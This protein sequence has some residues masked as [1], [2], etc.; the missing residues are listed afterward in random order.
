MHH[1]SGSLTRQA[2]LSKCYSESKVLSLNIERNHGITQYWGKLEGLEDFQ[3]IILAGGGMLSYYYI[4]LD[5]TQEEHGAMSKRQLGRESYKIRDSV[6][7]LSP[8]N[9]VT[10]HVHFL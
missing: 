3:A 6:S 2:K 9:V 10:D 1:T 8:D 4:I 7:F 5:F